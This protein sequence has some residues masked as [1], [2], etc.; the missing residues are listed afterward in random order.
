MGVFSA[1][2]VFPFPLAIA[3]H[4][5]WDLGMVLW[6]RS[7]VAA[8]ARWVAEAQQ[9]KSEAPPPALPASLLAHIF[10]ARS[11]ELSRLD[12][13]GVGR[14]SW[15]ARD[16]FFKQLADAL[17][18]ERDPGRLAE[19]LSALAAGRLARMDAMPVHMS[20]VD[21]S[22]V[23]AARDLARAVNRLNEGSQQPA[24]SL[25]LV[26]G[27]RQAYDELK[28]LAR[29]HGD[30]IHV[31]ASGAEGRIELPKV[32]QVFLGWVGETA[33]TL[34]MSRSR[35]L[36]LVGDFHSPFMARALE[37]LEKLPLGPAN[38]ESLI[39]AA[40]ALAAAA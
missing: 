2:L 30:S 19:A 1:Y 24:M 28:D 4:G 32:E 10:P 33:V 27:S 23:P 6:E 35:G 22:D 9:G 12:S 17:G 36:A 31:M 37:A 40:K 16:L 14:N 13:R 8:A 29:G 3:I 7:R 5:I 26:A 25:F 39:R 18:D 15:R 21:E 20:F 11:L 38:F 34:S